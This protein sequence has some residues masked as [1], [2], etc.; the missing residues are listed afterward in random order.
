MADTVDSKC[1][2]TPPSRYQIVFLDQQR[3]H[4]IYD[5]HRYGKFWRQ[6]ECLRKNEMQYKCYARNCNHYIR[7]RLTGGGRWIVSRYHMHDMDKGISHALVYHQIHSQN[8]QHAE[9][10]KKVTKQDAMLSG[11]PSREAV[12]SQML[13]NPALNQMESVTS[14]FFICLQK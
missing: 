7:I 9:L 2:Q 5:N 13:Q 11:Q 4:I 10:I 6:P 1:H 14:T 3:Q 12:E 8:C